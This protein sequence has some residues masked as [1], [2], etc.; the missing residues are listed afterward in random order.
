[1]DKPLDDAGFDHDV[2]GAIARSIREL[3]RIP[4]IADTAAALGRDLAAVE[5]S[6]VRMI[7]GHVFIPRAGSHEIYAYDPFCADQTDFH[8]TAGGRD[9]WAI[10]GWDAL[11]LPPALG[12]TG[13]IEARCA[14]CEKPI[15]VEVG[16]AGTARALAGAVLQIGVPARDFWKDIYFT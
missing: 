13:T 5:A 8:V 15:V 1:M 11:G 6:F 2:R 10:C 16:L 12:T 3:G 9:W 4:T 14:D 7:E